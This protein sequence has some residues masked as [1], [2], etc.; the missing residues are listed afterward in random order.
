VDPNLLPP[1]PPVAKP[2]PTQVAVVCQLCGTRT[3]APLEKIGQT[4]KCPDC[5][6]LNEVPPLKEPPAVKT[7][8]PTLEGTE[9]YGMSDVVERPKYR[10]LQAT[11]GEYEVLSALDP[12]SVE[13]RLTVPGQQPRKARP[14]ATAT[15]EPAPDEE[16]SLS[17]AVERV[18]V[19]QI[20]VNYVEIEP[21]DAMYDGRYEDGAIG[22]AVDPKAPDAWKRAPFVYGILG[23]LWQPAVVMRLIGFGVWLGIMAALARLWVAMARDDGQ[24]QIF[25]LLI[26]W[27]AIPVGATW[28]VAFA[29]AVQSIIEAT[30][31]GETDVKNW[32][33]WNV[34]EW[35]AASRFILI[36]AFIAGLPGGL[37]GAATLAASTNDPAMAA[38][39]IAAPPVLSWMVLFPFVLYSMMVEDTVFAVASAEAFRSLQVAADGWVFFYMY[40]IA[41]VLLAVGAAAMM[42][43]DQFLVGALGSCA[44]VA[45]LIVYARLL[46]RL[47]W[48]T[49]QREAKRAAA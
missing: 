30:A 35:F 3:Y 48:Y 6:T 32:P 22:D 38:F 25:A 13:H 4:I 41:L 15:A 16:V 40:S 42:L 47:M 27:G 46:G 36:A 24:G 49:G 33:D 37:L 44:M 14:A 29:A 17:P 11:R 43:V 18:T 12:A 10:P 2:K 23:I 39:G 31:N 7:A 1:P 45:V 34:Y 28:L 8:G 21:E 19:E 5:H 9:E 26:M 20:P